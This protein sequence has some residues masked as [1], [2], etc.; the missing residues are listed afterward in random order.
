MPGG[1]V[2]AY[3]LAPMGREEVEAVRL[4]HERFA[5]RHEVA[6]EIYADDAEWMAAREDPD[7]TTHVGADAIQAYYTQWPRPSRTSSSRGGR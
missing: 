7:S 2:T 4:Q 5:D 1:V 3:T 6:R